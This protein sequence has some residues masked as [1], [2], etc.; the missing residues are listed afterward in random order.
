MKRNQIRFIVIL[1][2]FAITGIILI[3]TYWLQKSWNIHEKQLNQTIFIALQNVAEKLSVY[4]QTVL[5]NENPVNQL[6]SNYF[7][8]NVNSVIDANILDYY[9]RT[10]FDKLNISTD[11]EYAIYDCHDDKMVYGNYVSAKGEEKQIKLSNNLPKYS[12]YIYYFGINFP[13]KIDY[14][15]GD[16]LLWIVFSAILLIS[17][18]FFSYSIFII[19]QQKRLSELQKD[20]IN[21]MTHEFKTPISSIN[22]SADV[23]SDPDILKDPKRLLNYGTII[24]QENN[25]LNKQVEKVLQIAR[26]EKSGFELKNEKIELNKLISDVADNCRSSNNLQKVIIT[27]RFDGQIKTIVADKLHLT[28]I[29]HNLL[30]NA[31]KYSD[32]KPEINIETRL[33]EKLVVVS[34]ADNGPGISKEYQHKV[35]QKFFRVP[36]GNIHNVKGFGLGLYYV[37]SICEAHRWKIHLESDRKRGTKF[38]IEIPK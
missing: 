22:I 25:R 34:V 19:L 23:I 12:E 10:E 32:G 3:Q 26:I 35:F 33:N 18:I 28:N 5:P 38:I 14:L 27:T 20:F 17:V 6:S 16:M 31:V 37:K 2:T 7:V 13:S 24:K 36:T 9:L 1:G 11:Y 15:S 21:N 8:V 29:F 30:D 4:N